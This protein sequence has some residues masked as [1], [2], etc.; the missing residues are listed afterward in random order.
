MQTFTVLKR[1]EVK[2]GFNLELCIMNGAQQAGGKCLTITNGTEL[3]ERQLDVK[4]R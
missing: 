4:P 3:A 2:C 1:K